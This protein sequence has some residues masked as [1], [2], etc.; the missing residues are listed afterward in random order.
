[1]PNLEDHAQPALEKLLQSDPD[2]L[3]AELGLRQKAIVDDPAEAGRF[4]TTAT[5]EA[6][7]AGPL[8][9]LKELGQ[10]FFK[11][12]SKNAYDLV[13]GDDEAN[14]AARQ[15]LAKAFNSGETVFASTLAALMV[16]SFG[17][18]PAIA[19]VVAALVVK[20]FLKSAYG[21]MCSVW[22]AHLPA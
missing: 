1:M 8:D 7:F 19:A 20:L 16:T 2:Q 14:A 9:V 17:L 5:Y 11:N 6:E 18:A 10:S 22:K 21:A 3:Y 12:V 4:E 13:C 15:K